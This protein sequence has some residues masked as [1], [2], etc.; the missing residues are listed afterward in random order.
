MWA[1]AGIEPQGAWYLEAA[2]MACADDGQRAEWLHLSARGTY[3]A[4]TLEAPTAN[5]VEG[6]P[7]RSIQ[8]RIASIPEKYDY[9]QIRTGDG[10][11]STG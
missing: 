9:R 4:R 2:R 7:I 3:L 8:R 1:T 10:V 6:D 11:Q 5:L